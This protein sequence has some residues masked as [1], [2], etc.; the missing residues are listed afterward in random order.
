MEAYLVAVNSKFIHT[1]A[2]VRSL[3]R[4]INSKVNLDIDFGEYTINQNS[5]KVLMDLYIK[6]ANIYGFSM[7]IFNLSYLMPV[8]MDLKKL[9]P[10]K[11]FFAGGPEVSYGTEDFLRKNKE[12][13][14][15]ICGEGEQ[16]VLQFLTA[17][18]GLTCGQ[19]KE[20]LYY[21]PIPGV[22]FLRNGEYLYGGENVPL[23]NLDEIPFLYTE[24]ELPQLKN[25]ILYYESSRGCPFH[26]S[27][28]LS[29]RE[30]G[31]RV[32]SLARVFS[33]LQKF[34]TANVRLVKFVDRTFNFNKSRALEIW[35]FLRE[36]DNGYTEFHF[37]ISAWLLD[38]ECLTFLSSIRP[39]L[40]RFEIGIQSTNERTLS[41]I[42]RN[43]S[44]ERIRN[45]LEKMRGI[46]IPIHVDLI[47][48][49]PYETYEIFKKSFN[50]AFSLK[51]NCLQ[52]G[53][54]KVLKGAPISMQQEYGY[55]FKSSPPYEVL[56]NR[57][58]TYKE[59]HILKRIEEVLELYYNAGICAE[60]LYIICMQ[61]FQ[62]DAFSFFEQFSEWLR[63]KQFFSVSHKVHNLFVY[64]YNFICLFMNRVDAEVLVAHDLLSFE[65]VAHLP[66]WFEVVQFVQ[67]E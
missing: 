40:F 6:Q 7:Y 11:I 26:C 48:G 5:D 63:D 42:S 59:I 31:V 46:N 55:V 4:Y 15:V 21:H 14:F 64:L 16:T 38:D 62:A 28:C 60:S 17:T 1:A 47:A 34:L 51:P 8:I 37:E 41:A 44:Y 30:K 33:D 27:Y 20:L 18:K 56:Y 36:F 66:E 65:K 35:K 23:C 3:C 43:V 22:A 45:V 67:V 24:D 9:Y 25:R 50:D 19:A 2:A 58:I 32:L 13:D 57:Y 29:S 54:L 53:F 10:D 52:L 12:V 61:I 49:L 39:G